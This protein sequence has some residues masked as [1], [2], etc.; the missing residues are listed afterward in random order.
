ME[1]EGWLGWDGKG[2]REREGEIGRERDDWKCNG[3]ILHYILYDIMYDILYDILYDI[4]V[5]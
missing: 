4:M 3:F 1:R 2:E 5:V